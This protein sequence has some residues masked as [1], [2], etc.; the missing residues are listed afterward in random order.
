M[1]EFFAKNAGRLQM[2]NNESLVSLTVEAR[3]VADVFS[4]PLRAF[5]ILQETFQVHEIRPL[6]DSAAAVIME[7][8]TGKF[9]LVFF[10]FVKGPNKWY[11]FFPT[12]SHI[13]AMS[14]VSSIKAEIERR[15]YY[16]AYSEEE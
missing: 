13:L 4:N 11:Y 15:N 10:Y 5:N 8:N 6:S 16:A 1:T 3:R 14:Y 9:A 12:D 2:M 7:K